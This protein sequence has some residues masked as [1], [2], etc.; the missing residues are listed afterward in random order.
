MA[1]KAPMKL[2]K[3]PVEA[4]NP[5]AVAPAVQ[6]KVGAAQ[7]FARQP[8]RPV[9]PEAMGPDKDEA[10]K[11]K[12]MG[13]AEIF[14]TREVVACY[15]RSIRSQPEPGPPS[16]LSASRG[17]SNLR[18]TQ[19]ESQTGIACKFPEDNFTAVDS[20]IPQQQP[21]VLGD[22]VGLGHGRGKFV[23]EP[24]QTGL[25]ARAAEVYAMVTCLSGT[26]VLRV[27]EED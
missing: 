22:K 5:A 12:K 27:T 15:E 24:V 1:F 20:Y 17:W 7:V 10:M 9:A 8:P 14:G 21:V 25:N 6:Q 19:P 26:T 23:G 13:A 11:K 3:R 4:K 2:V 18:K 16:P